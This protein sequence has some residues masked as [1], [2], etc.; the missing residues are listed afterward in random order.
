ML[1]KL[2][3]WECKTEVLDLC[4]FC[5]QASSTNTEQARHSALEDATRLRAELAA[6]TAERNTLSAEAMRLRAELEQC[7]WA[8]A[9]V[10]QKGAGMQ[11]FLAASVFAYRGCSA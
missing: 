3:G 1:W 11:G 5:M 4:C 9:A 7:R 2:L 6:A 10:V 8:P